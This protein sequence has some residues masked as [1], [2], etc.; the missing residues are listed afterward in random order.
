MPSDYVTLSVRPET[1][2]AIKQ[3]K[4]EWMSY[5][6]FLRKTALSEVEA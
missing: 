5:D 3:V 6:S 1:R 2:D 4:P